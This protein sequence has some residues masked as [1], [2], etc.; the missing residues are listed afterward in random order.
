MVV[1]DF[2]DDTLTPGIV[3][4]TVP[5]PVTSGMA[6]V[7][8][9]PKGRLLAFQVIPPEKEDAPRA[10]TTPDWQ[11]LFAAAEL[12][13]AQLR[14][15]TPAWASLA[16]SDVR[17]A[18]EG[19]WPGSDQ[20]LRVEAA[21]LQGRP[22]F[23]RLI[24]P[25]TR[26]E[27]MPSEEDEA[28]KRRTRTVLVAC[29]GGTVILGGIF[30]AYRN[31]VR[32]RGDRRGAFR[33]AVF[34]F[35]SHMLLWACRTHVV[36]GLGAFGLF[37]VALCN[38]LFSAAVVWAIYLAVE[39]YIR[40]HWPQTI[41]SWSRLLA[42]R[43]R[44]PLVGRDVLFGVLLGVAWLVIVDVSYLVIAQMGGPPT[45]G[46]T[47]YLRGGRHILGAWVGQAVSSVQGTLMF[48]FMLF[49]LRVLLRRPWLAAT[50]FVALFATSR[51]LGTEYPAV[52]V[53]ASIAIFG[54]VAYAGVRF[55]LITLAAGLFTVDLVVSAP[56]AA[57]LSSW[58]APATAFVFL[59][60]LAPAVWGF[61]TSL[62]GQRLWSDKLFD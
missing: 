45:L 32:G 29:V 27:R 2:Q 6:N 5:P 15:V 26:P 54:I 56:M 20:P 50:A 31:Y 18:W 13:P 28:S 17:A 14:P 48:F 4:P 41:I 51:I 22:V 43:L 34:V 38:S 7:V 11:P 58:Y 53:P 35:A 55:G 12:D 1:T 33:L 52:Q 42:G 36:A 60:V 39:P 61:Y 30:L 19:T 40:R 25:W 9:D 44:D 23:F 59:A 8:L 21:A 24:G 47:E 46:R 49:L 16:A 62:G 37:L 57:S 3:T 10:P